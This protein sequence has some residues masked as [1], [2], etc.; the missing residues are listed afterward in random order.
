[1]DEL[2]NLDGTGAY[3]VSREILKILNSHVKFINGILDGMRLPGGTCVFLAADDGYFPI[4]TPGTP[5]PTPVI[6][7][8]MCYIVANGK[9]I[10]NGAQR[11]GH[12]YML[13]N[14]SG[15]SADQLINDSDPAGRTIN[16]TSTNH[17]VV[18]L[19][20]EGAAVT[21]P[22][23]YVTRSASLSAANPL[24]PKYKFYRLR[25][26]FSYRLYT[27]YLN[28][29]NINSFS[30]ALVDGS[31]A[32]SGT[33][34]ISETFPNIMRKKDDRLIIQLIIK[35]PPTGSVINIPIFTNFGLNQETYALFGHNLLEDSS[36]AKVKLQTNVALGII[37]M[38]SSGSM[39][40]IIPNYNS[41]VSRWI[42]ING[43]IKLI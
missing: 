42:Q 13:D 6:E 9:L 16:L 25:D 29:L 12:I 4:Q 32:Q 20:I 5:T 10:N 2:I 28:F 30:N 40:T 19:E 41:N 8:A 38:P 3:P 22:N 33:I 7:N 17:D 34:G 21:F 36:I 39:L 11:R 18:D 27:N 24:N 15:I 37:G 26:I 35:V 31:S 14:Y 1:M 23:V 43:D